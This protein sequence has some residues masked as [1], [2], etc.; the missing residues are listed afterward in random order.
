MGSLSEDVTRLA[1]ERIC[2][3][4]PSSLGD[5]VHSLPILPALRTLWPAAHI[6]WVVNSAFRGLIE[7]HPD[8]NRVIAYDKGG[9][10]VTRRGVLAMSKLCGE[11]VKDE[12]DLTIDLQG[13][14]R[15]GIMTAATGAALRVGLDDARE[16]A[17]WFYTHR[18]SASRLS[19]HAVDRVM[20]VAEALGAA[21]AEPS[22]HLPIRE[23]DEEWARKTL[24]SI[25][26][27]RLI[28]NIGA[29]WLT[30][31]W[32]VEHFAE[33]ARRAVAEFGAGLIAVGGREDRELV[34]SLREKLAGAPIVDL[35]GATSLLQLAALAKQ[36]DLYLSNDTGP[37]HLAAAAGASVVGIYTCTDPKL[38]GPYGPRAAVVK[39]CVWCAPSFVKN[40]DRLE[41]FTELSPDRVWPTVHAR[42]AHA[43]S[44]AA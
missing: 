35:C 23:L 40:C 19:V 1:P 5:V 32:P 37:I 15:S 9:S 13:L 17:G 21:P 31:R 29:R 43:Q 16:G 4:K 10:G 26:G 44:S 41:C 11:L 7:G 14:L 24:A 34:D 20:R 3:I 27:P 30:K 28:L 38:T 8:L 25:P 42:L 12:F 39:S 36:S 33:V 2:I 22:F 18:V 6:S